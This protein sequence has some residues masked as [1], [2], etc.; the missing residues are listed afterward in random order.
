MRKGILIWALVSG[1][2]MVVGGIGPWVTVFGTSVN[3]THGDGWIVIGAAVVGCVL[4]F[5]LRRFRAA[6]S[7]AIATGVIAMLTAGY[8]R[9]HLDKLIKSG[10]T[11]YQNVFKIGWGLNLALVAS[12]SFALAGLFGVILGPRRQEAPLAAPAPAMAPPP[13]PSAPAMS[14]PPPPA[15]AEGT[16]QS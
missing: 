13:P 8:D 6:G 3:G 2:L 11:A 16:E 1:A 10:G 7:A 12:L 9:G 5:V 4:C 15:P 14:P